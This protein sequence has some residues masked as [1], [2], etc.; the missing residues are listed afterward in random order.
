MVCAVIEN[1]TAS[2]KG[3]WVV[4]ERTHGKGQAG[5]R[6]LLASKFEVFVLI[7]HPR[8]AA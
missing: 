8:E 3:R 6:N 7:N 1:M 5:E 2:D 4:D